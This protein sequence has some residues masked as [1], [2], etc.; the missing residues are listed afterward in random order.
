MHNFQLF[1]KTL[2]EIF[3]QFWGH[4]H[5][6]LHLETVP[7]HFAEILTPSLYFQNSSNSGEEYKTVEKCITLKNSRKRWV[8]LLSTLR[9]HLRTAISR[10]IM[11]AF[12]MKPNALPIFSGRAQTLGKV[13]NSR[14]WCRIG[15]S[16]QIHT[17][18][19]QGPEFVPF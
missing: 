13:C 17:K 3:C 5:G 8:S 9:A 12:K 6:F 15:W 14:E 18:L 10:A 16:K 4:L 11:S 2:G 7:M 19:L 1:Q